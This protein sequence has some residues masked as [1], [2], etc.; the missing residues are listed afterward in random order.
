MPSEES[1]NL[2]TLFKTFA[3]NFPTDE[4]HYLSRCIYDQVSQAGAEC[5]TVSSEDI[6]ISV[7][8]LTVPCKWFRPAGSEKSKH[9]LLFMH[10]GGF[11]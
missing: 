9:V 4:N 6:V 10:G 11:W 8:G 5:P 1:K 2:A 7:D 3:A